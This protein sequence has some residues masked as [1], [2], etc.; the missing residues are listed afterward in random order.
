MKIIVLGQE[1][2]EYTEL[3]IFE[4]KK[5]KKTENTGFCIGNHTFAMN[6]GKLAVKI[7]LK[8]KVGAKKCTT[9]FFEDQW[10]F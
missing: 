4:N 10:P 8:E 7:P 6:N 9:F 5:K 3:F 1:V 2:P